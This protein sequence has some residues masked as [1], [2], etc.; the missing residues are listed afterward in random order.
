MG[1]E[2]EGGD[3]AGGK[4]GVGW[5]VEQYG[6]ASL[7]G[8]SEFP[9][10]EETGKHIVKWNQLEN[11]ETE[12]SVSSCMGCGTGGKDRVSHEIDLNILKNMESSWG[13]GLGAMLAS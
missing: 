7:P 1:R 11:V 4:R 13:K 5:L 6:E 2:G 10:F 12:E 9:G 8:R 3:L